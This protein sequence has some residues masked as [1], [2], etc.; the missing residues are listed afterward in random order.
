MQFDAKYVRKAKLILRLFLNVFL[1]AIVD[2]THNIKCLTSTK[3]PGI[4]SLI[5]IQ[6]FCTFFVFVEESQTC[7]RFQVIYLRTLSLKGIQY[8]TL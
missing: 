1:P 4:V 5:W 2:F 7:F 6:S 3:N 8:I